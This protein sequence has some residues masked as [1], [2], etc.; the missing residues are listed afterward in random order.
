MDRIKEQGGGKVG[1][2][3]D[4][5]LSRI[6][7]REFLVKESNEEDKRYSGSHSFLIIKNSGNR[8]RCLNIG[9]CGELELM[10][11]DF[12]I[13]TGPNGERWDSTYFITEYDIK[14]E[15]L[16]NFDKGV[17]LGRGN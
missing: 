12:I 8:Y 11:G 7:A 10:E 2:S 14:V 3:L 4:F 1:I 9:G 15:G 16:P 5:K 6:K 13:T 17:M